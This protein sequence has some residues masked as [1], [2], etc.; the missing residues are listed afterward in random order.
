MA[1]TPK[2]HI[3]TLLDRVISAVESHRRWQLVAT[4][5]LSTL[6]MFAVFGATSNSRAEHA[7]WGASSLV[8]IATSDLVSGTTLTEVNTASVQAPQQFIARGAV[9]TLLVGMTT[10]RQLLA[11]SI[12][13]TLDLASNANTT[14]PNGWRIVAFPADVIIP[15]L[16]IGDIVD[17]VTAGLV[18][19]ADARVMTPATHER[20]VEIAV[21]ADLA[22]IVAA[23]IN[24][25]DTSL[26]A[27]G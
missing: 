27:S 15:E 4:A 23:A 1:W 10:S 24:N 8:L 17:V 11:S 25:G 18:I 26:V 7:R 20:G 2:L 16:A 21:P 9:T 19:A 13:T 6:A 12:I 3:S 14:L 22:A 5:M